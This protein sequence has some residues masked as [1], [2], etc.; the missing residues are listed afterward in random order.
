MSG[1]FICYRRQDTIAYAGRLYDRL[2]THFGLGRVFMDIN[3]LEPG[4]DFVKGLKQ[5]VA[6][7]SVL[8]AVIGKQWLTAKD[9]RGWS[10]LDDPEDFVRLEIAAALEHN[11]RVIPLLVAGGQMP[12][13]R[14]MPAAL[15][16]LTQRQALEIRDTSFHPDISRLIN[17][18]EKAIELDQE[19]PIRF[20]KA[21]EVKTDPESQEQRGC[22]E[23]SQEKLTSPTNSLETWTAVDSQTNNDIALPRLEKSKHRKKVST[24][25][26]IF[27]GLLS[28]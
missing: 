5:A 3:R 19:L 11:L 17:T 10:R 20:A 9:E 8:I 4:T 28:S 27:K 15:K 18:L 12:L 22:E 2:V 24:R 23:R 21:A 16:K 25:W 13:S 7:C 14:E 26:T 1:I 6:S